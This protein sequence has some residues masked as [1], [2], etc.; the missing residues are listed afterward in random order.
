ML[1]VSNRYILYFSVFNYNQQFEATKSVLSGEAELALVDGLS[2]I[3]DGRIASNP[4]LEMKELIDYNQYYGIVVSGET[5]RLGNCIN[6]Y[7]RNN[8]ERV[9]GTVESQHGSLWN[10]R[11]IELVSS[12]EINVVVRYTGNQ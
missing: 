3:N 12:A 1:I 5:E 2:L 7:M 11:K 10:V 4:H 6:I 8:W 9:Q